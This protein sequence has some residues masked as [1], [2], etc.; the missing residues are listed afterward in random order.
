MGNAAE[1]MNQNSSEYGS[2]IDH[3]MSLAWDDAF[4]TSPGK[5][6]KPENGPQLT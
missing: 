2:K 1:I 5:F 6:K 4:F 3:R